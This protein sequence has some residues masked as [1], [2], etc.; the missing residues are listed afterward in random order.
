MGWGVQ[1]ETHLS[2]IENK[3]PAPPRLP[4]AHAHSGRACGH[5]RKARQRPGSVVGVT[6]SRATLPRSVRLRGAPQFTGAFTHRLKSPLFLVLVRENSSGGLTRLGIVVGRRNAPRAVDRS[7]LKRLVRE[8]FRYLRSLLGPVDLVVRLRAP[9]S[10]GAHRQARE[11]IK[12]LL[13]RAAA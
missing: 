2:A 6:V 1:D 9:V 11:E 3:A 13:Q 10:I 7:R 5:Q 4:G 8:E 12:R